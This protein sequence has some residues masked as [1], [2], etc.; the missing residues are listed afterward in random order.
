[1]RPFGATEWAS[2]A[3]VI[4]KKAEKDGT[5]RVRWVSDFREL[6]KVIER[7]VHR[8]LCHEFKMHSQS[9]K[10][11]VFFSKLDLSMCHHTFE[12]TEEAKNSCTI[13]TPCGKFQ[14][15]RLAMGVSCAPDMAQ[16]TM[17]HVMRGIEDAD[18]FIDDIG[19]FSNSWMEH[20]QLLEEI[21]QRLQDN[22]F[23]VSPM[24]C[25]WGVKETDWL[26]H[27]LTPSGLKPWRKKVDGIPQME[28]P[29]NVKQVRAFIGAV[30]IIG[31]CGRVAHTSS[32]H[33][34]T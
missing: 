6:N 5:Q 21:S 17:E 7:R 1:M 34:Q 26:G 31:I 16:E 33:L 23:A 14:H 25:E 29:Q 32:N 3:F 27:W 4:P 20:L 13:V 11:M 24:K 19:A 15:C 22:G 8:V 30:T 2:P 18:A 10:V 9:A 12:L 28:R